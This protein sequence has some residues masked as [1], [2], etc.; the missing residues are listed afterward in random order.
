[1]LKFNK[2]YL[3]ITIFFLLF[4]GIFL[5]FNT[6][7]T[8]DELHEQL[9]WDYNKLIFKNIISGN[10]EI[11]PYIDKYYGIGF[12]LISQPFQYVVLKLFEFNN[13]STFGSKLILKHPVVFIFYFISSLF[14]YKILKKVTNDKK[15]SIISAFFYLLYPYLLG[16]SFFNSKDIPF[17]SIW[18]ICTYM[19]CYI[20]EKLATENIISFNKII[21]LSIITAFL[22]S[23]RISGVLIFLQ[24]L[25]T[26][27]IFLSYFKNFVNY[28]YL[29]SKIILFLI[30][31]S[32]FTVLF[33]PIFW[34]NPLE[35][36]NAIKFMSNHYND[37]CT[38]T[39]GKC[40]KS[41]Q[42]DPTYIFFLACCKNTYTDY[43]RY[44]AT[45]PH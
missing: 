37:I 24:Y 1:M 33:Y 43:N 23:I 45:T 10:N 22:F 28:K 34:Q 5:S 12:N 2:I 11:I 15:F 26:L 35:F 25:F 36:I 7:I 4:A 29:F 31:C 21:I 6:G 3:Y 20:F 30:S 8:H 19:S 16:H 13:I 14:F 18:L 9:N 44:F 27:I 32:F 38:I 39:F 40:L 42:L 17:L 41:L